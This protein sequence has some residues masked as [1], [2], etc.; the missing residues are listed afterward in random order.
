MSRGWV[1]N[2]GCRITVAPGHLAKEIMLK[3]VPDISDSCCG[4]HL[5]VL[6]LLP[7]VRPLARA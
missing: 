3:K 2:G 4:F 6:P 1:E 7:Q 5:G